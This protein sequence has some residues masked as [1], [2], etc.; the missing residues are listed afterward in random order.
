MFK[1]RLRMLAWYCLP[2]VIILILL[3]LLLK[4]IID[5]DQWCSLLIV[6]ALLTWLSSSV[7][8]R[9]GFFV[10]PKGLWQV[11]SK[12]KDRG[13]Y[14]TEACSPSWFRARIYLK[15]GKRRSPELDWRLIFEERK[16][17]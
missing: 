12:R 7:G 1:Y 4:G 5:G 13:F 17:E 8:T 3:V 9:T 2:Q 6:V 16:D 11:E 10:K 15:A 14:Q